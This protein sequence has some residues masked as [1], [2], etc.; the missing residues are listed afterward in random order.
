LLHGIG[1]EC[2][3]Y[4]PSKLYDYFWTGRPIWALT[5]R[6]PQL[7]E[8][9]SARNAYLSA[10]TDDAGVAQTLEKIWQDWQQKNLNPAMGD[11]IGVNQAVQKILETV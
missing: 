4:I 11:P 1:E 7:N 6:N 2:A 3:E 10:N 5:H 9:L 8:I